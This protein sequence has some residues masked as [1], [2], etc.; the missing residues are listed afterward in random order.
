MKKYILLILT[1]IGC[2]CNPKQKNETNDN[3]AIFYKS[4][5]NDSLYTFIHS[6]DSFPNSSIR[7]EYLVQFKEDEAGDI[8]IVMV[9]NEN[10]SPSWVLNSLPREI[11]KYSYHTKGGIMVDGKPVL[12][13]YIDD[14]DI[15]NIIDISRLDVALGT[16]IDSIVTPTNR[17]PYTIATYKLY[18]IDKQDSLILLQD[19]YLGKRKFDEQRPDFHW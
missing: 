6:I 13:R 5:I 19:C 16:N 14:V 3:I 15:S 10:I 18:K 7:P 8:L 12:I 11:N 2:S 4:L 17:E 1:I 9:A